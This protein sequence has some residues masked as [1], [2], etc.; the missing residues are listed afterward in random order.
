MYK[1]SNMI[2]YFHDDGG[3]TDITK[4][5]KKMASSPANHSQHIVTANVPK[6]EFQITILIHKSEE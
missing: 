5:A 4:T 6:G 3:P 2:I 1:S